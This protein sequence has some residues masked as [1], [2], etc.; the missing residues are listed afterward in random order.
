MV[1][2]KPLLKLGNKK[3]KREG[4]GTTPLSYLSNNQSLKA[5]T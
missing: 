4:L 3:I 2:S 1:F 5:L